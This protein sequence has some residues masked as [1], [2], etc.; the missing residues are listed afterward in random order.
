MANEAGRKS[1]E[2]VVTS[3]ESLGRSRAAADR[4]VHSEKDSNDRAPLQVDKSQLKPLLEKPV[5]NVEHQPLGRR[6]RKYVGGDKSSSVSKR[7]KI[8]PE[9]TSLGATTSD[10]AGT[11][12]TNPEATSSG[13]TTKNTGGSGRTNP[14]ATTSQEVFEVE[15]GFDINGIETSQFEDFGPQ[16]QSLVLAVGSVYD[17]SRA[18]SGST[19]LHNLTSKPLAE[20]YSTSLR[21]SSLVSSETLC[22][23]NIRSVEVQMLQAQYDSI[24]SQLISIKS[25]LDGVPQQIVSSIAQNDRRWAKIVGK[26]FDMKMKN[27]VGTSALPT[28]TAGCQPTLSPSTSV[29]GAFTSSSNTWEVYRRK[30]P[31]TLPLR[32][33]DA[34]LKAEIHLGADEVEQKIFKDLTS[35]LMCVVLVSYR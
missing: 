35:F 29:A 14:D 20:A 21:L 4:R 10:L 6:A 24:N 3:D 17:S 1:G 28:S 7:P 34:L 2:E 13:A 33:K 26:V 9:A 19:V 8:I 15:E 12:R 32:T 11:G 16:P 25:L 30:L 23:S 31:F 22:T 27:F 5:P 18:A